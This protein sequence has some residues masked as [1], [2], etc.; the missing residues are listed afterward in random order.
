[1]YRQRRKWVISNMSCRK[2]E[3]VSWPHQAHSICLPRSDN[4]LFFF[5]PSTLWLWNR[6]QGLVIN[7]EKYKAPYSVNFKN[8]K[9][10][11]VLLK[12][13]ATHLS[14]LPEQKWFCLG[15]SILNGCKPLLQVLGFLVKTQP[16]YIK[17]Q[18]TSYSLSFLSSCTKINS[19]KEV[20]LTPDG[21]VSGRCMQ[22]L[23]WNLAT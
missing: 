1:M 18:F 19:L 7:K 17:L 21:S 6:K 15:Q 5:Y 13:N 22:F 10:W 8:K 4:L 14:T 3:Y 2:S 9:M 20:I 16:F 12:G 11:S 23:P